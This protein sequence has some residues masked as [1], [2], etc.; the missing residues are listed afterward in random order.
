MSYQTKAPQSPVTNTPQRPPG[1]RKELA[2]KL[3]AAGWGLFFIWVAVTLML[4]IEL[5][6]GL[7]G[8]GL[9]TIAGQGARKYVGLALEGGW[10]AVGLC[11]V[12]A[13]LWEL[14]AIQIP[15]FPFVL[16]VVGGGL[17]LAAVRGRG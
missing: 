4:E 17:L 12:L 7:L 14:L 10:V 2:E 6:V 8:V 16:L 5:G 1:E 11:F 3:D 15:F 13:G 9:I